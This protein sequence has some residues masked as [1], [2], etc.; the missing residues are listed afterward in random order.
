MF[1]LEKSRAS[2]ALSIPDPEGRQVLPRAPE[3]MGCQG[4]SSAEARNQEKS[5]RWVGWV[6]QL[7]K[8]RVFCSFVR[9]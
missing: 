6:T 2:E 4:G 5:P 7:E 8:G 3:T 1:Y 9:T